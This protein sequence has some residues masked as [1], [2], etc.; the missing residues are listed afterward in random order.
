[1]NK[2]ELIKLTAAACNEPVSATTRIVNA[3][4]EAITVALV[5]G[6]QVKI[7]DFGVFASTPTAARIGRNPSTGETVNIAASNRV[8]FKVSSVLKAACNG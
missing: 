3:M 8:T 7:A 5:E 6:E 2:T 1:M 4:L